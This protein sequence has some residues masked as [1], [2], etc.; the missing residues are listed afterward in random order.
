MKGPIT[1]KPVGKPI[2][3][4]VVE[5]LEEVL[6]MAKQGEID[7]IAI[8]STGPMGITRQAYERGGQPGAFLYMS[9]GHLQAA[10]L[11]TCEDV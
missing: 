6:A 10:I 5:L 9:I 7:G 2:N 8:A 4:A 11:G 1:L 3:T